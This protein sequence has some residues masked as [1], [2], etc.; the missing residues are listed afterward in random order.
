MTLKKMMIQDLVILKMNE[1]NFIEAT[2]THVNLSNHTKLKLNEINKIND[3]FNPDIQDWKIMCKKLSKY[4]VAFDYFEIL[5]VLSATRQG[6]WK[7]YYVFYKRYW[8]C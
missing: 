4:I 7:I 3:Y 8:G 2:N 1:C 5:I 6:I